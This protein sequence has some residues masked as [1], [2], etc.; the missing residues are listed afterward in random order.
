MMILQLIP[1][2]IIT[3]LTTLV[4][5]DNLLTSF[6]PLC[7][8]PVVT[9]IAEAAGTSGRFLQEK[10]LV[11]PDGG[12]YGRFVRNLRTKRKTEVSAEATNNWVQNY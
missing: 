8:A 2:I 12:S 3:T 4:K 11:P 7:R 5:C 10:N 9:I 1:T 6:I